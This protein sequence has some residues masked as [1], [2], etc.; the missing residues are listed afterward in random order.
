[1]SFSYGP[2]FAFEKKASISSYSGGRA[3]PDT[4]GSDPRP[5]IGHG[6]EH[7]DVHQVIGIELHDLR[8]VVLEIG[9]Q[10]EDPAGNEVHDVIGAFL[11]EPFG[12]NG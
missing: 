7:D 4:V 11:P 9:L 10:S 2:L 1:M 5:M 6:V 12:I 8:P 3:I